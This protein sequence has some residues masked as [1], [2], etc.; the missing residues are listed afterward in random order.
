M[1]GKTEDTFWQTYKGENSNQAGNVFF[2]CYLLFLQMASPVALIKNVHRC[3][4]KVN[5]LALSNVKKK[6]RSDNILRGY[7]G[8]MEKNKTKPR[9]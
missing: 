1:R 9:V 8:L 5:E 6:E 7:Y 3:N 2:L 4:Q